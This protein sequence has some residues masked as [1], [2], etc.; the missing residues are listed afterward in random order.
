MQLPVTSVEIERQHAN[1]QLDCHIQRS[2]AVKPSTVQMDAYTTSCILEH[3]G[4]KQGIERICFG[5]S[6]KKVHRLLH[7]R[8]VDQT[9]PSYGKK[10]QSKLKVRAD[11]TATVKRRGKLLSGL[12]RPV[13]VY[14]DDFFIFIFY[15]IIS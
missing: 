3:Q 12:L 14:S 9:G 5:K 10:I 11:G 15:Y 7:A 1:I 4:L 6:S 13:T 2:N 8:T